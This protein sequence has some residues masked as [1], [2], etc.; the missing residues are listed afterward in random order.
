MALGCDSIVAVRYFE[1]IFQHLRR[2]G[3]SFY[4]YSY[5]LAVNRLT[6]VGLGSVWSVRSARGLWQNFS[7][8][9]VL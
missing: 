9:L 3:K 4:S 8:S 5:S 1:E 6:L 7:E 2:L